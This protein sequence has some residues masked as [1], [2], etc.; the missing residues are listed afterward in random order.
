MQLV[1][2]F[3]LSVHLSKFCIMKQLYTPLLGR[4]GCAQCSPIETHTD[5]WTYSNRQLSEQMLPDLLE[6]NDMER[7]MEKNLAT[8]SVGVGYYYIKASINLAAVS[9]E[10]VSRITIKNLC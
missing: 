4:C 6:V 1:P 10:F 3:C 7:Y 5:R 2:S 9:L 8:I